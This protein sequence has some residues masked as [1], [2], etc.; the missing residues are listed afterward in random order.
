M[1]FTRS[2]T[3]TAVAALLSLVNGQAPGICYSYG[4][5]YMDEGHYFINSQLT[6]RWSSVSY[7]EGCNEDNAEVLLVE[8]EGVNSQEYICD[9]IP[10]VCSLRHH[11]LGCN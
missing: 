8:P 6:E 11:D 9:Q 7:F 5:D 4:V 10:T 2:F 1:T 3:A